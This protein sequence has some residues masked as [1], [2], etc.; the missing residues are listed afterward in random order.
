MPY[1]KKRNRRSKIDYCN[2]CEKFESLTWDHVPPKSCFNNE[3][4]KYN[5]FYEGVNNEKARLTG[6]EL[7]QYITSQNGV[8]FRT[9]CATCNNSLLGVKYDPELENLAK[10]TDALV[11]S[12]IMLPPSVTTK[13]K[14][15]KLSRSIV[16][17]I[18]AAKDMYD[19]QVLTDK[20]LRKYFLDASSL[21]PRDMMLLFR[22]YPF[23]SIVIQ[24]DCIVASLNKE[25]VFPGGMSDCLS[26]YPVA[27]VL[28]SSGSNCGLLDLF[29]KCTENIDDEVDIPIDLSSHKHRN[30][31]V[32][33]HFLWPI[34]VSD[35]DYGAS[36][37]VTGSTSTSL[38]ARKTI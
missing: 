26:F 25:N 27:F 13:S 29:S 33:R 32:I 3:K 1:I 30:D 24:R 18:L 19:N 11:S 21:P 10:F 8:K 20:K 31:D 34:N 37:M 22:I 7:T 5:T 14:I 9:I 17:H 6:G 38:I 23:A 35:D 4:I 16:G 12:D 2:I 28:C 15:N 36:V